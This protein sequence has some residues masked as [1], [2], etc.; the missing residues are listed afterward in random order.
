MVAIAQV[1]CL[2]GYRVAWRWYGLVYWTTY[3][4]MQDANTHEHPYTS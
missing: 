2:V 4:L 3:A 1:T